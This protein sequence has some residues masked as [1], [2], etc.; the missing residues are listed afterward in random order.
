MLNS[1]LRIQWSWGQHQVY[2]VQT[3]WT[4]PTES[5]AVI[6]SVAFEDCVI[7]CSISIGWLFRRPWQQPHCG[8]HAKFLAPSD[9]YRRLSLLARPWQRPS[10][11]LSHS[12][13][14]NQCFFRPV[15]KDITTF[16]RFFLSSAARKSHSVHRPVDNSRLVAPLHALHASLLWLVVCLPRRMSRQL[17]VRWRCPSKWES[18]WVTPGDAKLSRTPYLLSPT[19]TNVHEEHG[20]VPTLKMSTSTW[21]GLRGD[22]N[23]EPRRVPANSQLIFQ[24]HE[25]KP[26]VWC[27]QLSVL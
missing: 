7:P 16:G 18:A 5:L 2:C 3:T 21:I 22:L 26:A 10:G 15:V 4:I 12:V 8:C 1:W 11:T 19:E 27:H 17:S 20:H 14:W 6:I 9:V 13:T 24:R 23:D 25:Q